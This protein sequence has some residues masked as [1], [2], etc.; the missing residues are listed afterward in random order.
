MVIEP[1][2]I[3]GEGGVISL[4]HILCGMSTLQSMSYIFAKCVC[5]N[6]IAIVCYLIVKKL[7]WP[8]GILISSSK[9]TGCFLHWPNYKYYLI[10]RDEQ[11]L[12]INSLYVCFS[13]PMK[14]IASPAI[15]KKW[16]LSIHLKKVRNGYALPKHLQIQNTSIPKSLI[17]EFLF[18]CFWRGRERVMLMH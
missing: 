16:L 12:T 14:L 10:F 6:K 9:S 4:F 1:E 17:T 7:F 5:R 2:L 13:H 11:K 18:V 8:Q 3:E 15:S